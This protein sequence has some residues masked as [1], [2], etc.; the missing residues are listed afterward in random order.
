MELLSDFHWAII[1]PLFPRPRP[2]RTRRGRPWIDARHGLGGI[3]WILRTGAPWRY[4]PGCF[5]SYQ[6]CHRRFQQWNADGT[7]HRIL[8]R[9]AAE[10]GVGSGEEA[11]IDGTY[12]PAR[13]GGLCVGRCRAGRA[14]KVM[15]IADD[16]G[17]PLS[18]SIADG[19]RHDVVLTN[20]ALDA[21]FVDSLP[22]RLVGD[23]AWDSGKA[24]RALAE[25]RDIELIAPKRGGKRPSARKQ[26]GRALRRARR[27]WK[28][29]RLFAWLK[30]FRRLVCRWENRAENYLGLLQLGCIV[31][32]LRQY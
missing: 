29:E 15:A 25:E 6:T 23:K 28:V 9:L 12:V 10:L 24:Q 2:G 1:E 18:I 17:L 4:L 13:R 20:Q 8:T 22:P 5:P 11:F 31:I 3:L 7:L 26:D 21:S 32:L 30:A 14:T 27:R 19:S 16:R